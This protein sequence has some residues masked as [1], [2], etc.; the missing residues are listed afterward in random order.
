MAKTAQERAASLQRESRKSIADWTPENPELSIEQ[1][2]LMEQYYNEY[3]ALP[4]RE[5]K[6]FL[7]VAM[8]ALED[9]EDVRRVELELE[10]AQD[11]IHQLNET[12]THQDVQ[13]GLLKELNLA[14][15]LA[16]DS[17]PVPQSTPQP[18]GAFRERRERIAKPES[19]TNAYDKDAKCIK[20]PY[21]TW[22]QRIQKKLELDADLFASESHKVEYAY[23]L[24][25]G[26]ALS[27]VQNSYA[28][29]EFTSI[30]KLLA[31]CDKMFLRR[32]AH[33]TAA[34]KLE[35]I[36]QGQ[37]TFAWY[38]LEFSK[39]SDELKDQSDDNL[40]ELLCRNL[41]DKYSTAIVRD[42]DELSFPDLVSVL[43]R[44]DEK[45][46]IQKDAQ[47][48]RNNTSST[49]L[50]NNRNRQVES[51]A[52]HT[53]SSNTLSNTSSTSQAIRAPTRTQEE[54][55]ICRDQRLCLKCCK[56]GH[57]ARDC[58]DRYYAWFPKALIVKNSGV[59][60]VEELSENA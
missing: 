19:F 33:L 14:S 27:F 15:Q 30:D 18:D 8:K 43:E 54:R 57:I 36:Y 35:N 1:R 10:D 47:D 24:I 21:K 20:M 59:H 60:V 3:N 5:Q 32:N 49:S 58:K 28:K 56:S 11:Q 41:N 7:L 9:T 38:F 13:I 4:D 26:P 2:N 52:S 37:R 44:I 16:R 31:H 50:Y 23:D 17:T 25:S 22:K 48:K 42:Q 39:W 34:S 29:G 12:T 46:I 51:Q 40:K 53:Q 6:R 45:M 55:D